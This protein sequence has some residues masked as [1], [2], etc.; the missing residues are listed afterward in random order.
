MVASNVV[1]D[2]F[3]E[4]MSRWASG[5]T[6]VTT[7]HEGGR[8]GL[9]ASAFS[10]VSLDPPL[11]LVCVDRRAESCE[12][13]RRSAHFGVSVLAAEQQAAA[14]QMARSGEDKFAGLP[15]VVGPVASQLLLEGALAQLEC[16][17]YRADEAGDHIIVLGEVLAVHVREA[18]P[19]VYFHRRF[20]GLG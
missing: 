20:R 15:F 7:V 8:S 9:T 16:R 10:S 1:M 11:V 13:L 4:A 2:G 19:L 6:V 18:E 3:R 5:V 17:T 14:L 12:P